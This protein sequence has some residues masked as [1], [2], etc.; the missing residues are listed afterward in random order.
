MDQNIL[1]KFLKKWEYQTILPISWETYMG[2]KKWQLEPY[3]EQ[4]NGSEL[5]KEYG[6]AVY[7]FI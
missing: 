7:L 1:W 6:R 5:G 4:Q 2:V 3:M